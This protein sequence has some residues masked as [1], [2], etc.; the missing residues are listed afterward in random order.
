MSAAEWDYSDPNAK[1]PGVC[2]TGKR[3]SP[4]NIVK[5]DVVEDPTLHKLQAVNYNETRTGSNY[6]IS[7]NGH[8]FVA[9]PVIDTTGLSDPH[10]YMVFNRKSPIIRIRMTFFGVQKIVVRKL[11]FRSSLLF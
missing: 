1:W 3:Q 7:N 8:G 11:F 10:P 6:S 5:V 2:Q 9:A 4:I